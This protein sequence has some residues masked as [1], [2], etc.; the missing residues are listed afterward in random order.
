MRYVLGADQC[1]D[2]FVPQVYTVRRKDLGV[3]EQCADLV[4]QSLTVVNDSPRW[5]FETALRARR[6]PYNYKGSI[7]EVGVCS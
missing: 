5:L 7:Y 1:V 2:G 3:I 4:K 6:I